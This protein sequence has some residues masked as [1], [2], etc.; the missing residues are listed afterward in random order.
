MG[1]PIST[2]HV[3]IGAVIGIGFARGV[4]ALNLSVLKKIVASWIITLP[5]S[6]IISS[7]IFLILKSVFV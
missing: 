5:V 4:S 6:A 7:I 3:L 1:L 2:T